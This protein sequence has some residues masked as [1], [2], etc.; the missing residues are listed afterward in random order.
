MCTSFTPRPRGPLTAQALF[1]VVTCVDCGS[2]V[3]LGRFCSWC[4]APLRPKDVGDKAR[5]VYAAV[6]KRLVELMHTSR[7]AGTAK[8]NQS[9]WESLARFMRDEMDLNPLHATPLDVVAWL[10]HSDRRAR[11][12]F[13]VAEC[14]DYRAAEGGACPGTLGCRTRLKHAAARTKVMQL[15]AYFRTTG[16]TSPWD[17]R[18]NTGNPCRAPQI[19]E[20]LSA[21]LKEQIAAGVHTDLA[22]LMAPGLVDALIKAHVRRYAVL[23]KEAQDGEAEPLEA[24]WALQQATL[25]S[26]LA[27]VPDRSFDV[28]RLTFQDITFVEAARDGSGTPRALRVSLG[29]NKTALAHGKARSVLLLDSVDRLVSPISLFLQLRTV[30][31]AAGVEVLPLSG[32]I[33]YPKASLLDKRGRAVPAQG[34]LKAKPMSHKQIHAVLL[35]AQRAL[36]PEY[37]RMPLTPHSFRAA[38]AAAALARGEPVE[39][40]LHAFNWRSPSMLAHYV[41]L[42]VLYGYKE[43]MCFDLSDDLALDHE[44]L[45]EGL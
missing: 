21:L 16:L 2:R 27:H 12:T 4:A 25:L 19:Q 30:R 7:T 6:Y 11:T 18:G 15:Q 33:F 45:G 26:F 1:S 34:R 41:E 36:G 9:V 31:A 37:E 24:L 10:I 35:E 22:P 28:A 23:W 42:R 3:A 5:A 20:Y 44:D 38:A 43:P 39:A 14:P 40:I 8:R 29:L 32:L 13:H 17:G